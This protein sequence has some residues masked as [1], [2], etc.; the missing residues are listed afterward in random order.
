MYVTNAVSATLQWVIQAAPQQFMPRTILESGTNGISECI[1]AW[2]ADPRSTMTPDRGPASVFQDILAASDI[3]LSEVLGG[4]IATPEAVDAAIAEWA[5]TE[6]AAI[7]LTKEVAT[8]TIPE[9]ATELRATLER[10]PFLTR[11]TNTTYRVQARGLPLL[12]GPHAYTCTGGDGAV[13]LRIGNATESCHVDAAALE[14]RVAGTRGTAFN[15]LMEQQ[16][17]VFG[18]Y[19]AA[20]VMS[21]MEWSRPHVGVRLIAVVAVF[22]LWCASLAANKGLYI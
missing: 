8:L 4:K 2:T 20:I 5:D 21:G 22:Y 12:Y 3:E 17:Y 15:A 11:E 14:A 7:G 10:L 18:A 19:L 9:A 1:K 16:P 6:T 13:T